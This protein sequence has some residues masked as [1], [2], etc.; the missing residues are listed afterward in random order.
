M[1]TVCAIPDR[2]KAL[3]Y[4]P[5]DVRIGQ[6]VSAMSV[7]WTIFMLTGCNDS[8][9]PAAQVLRPAPIIVR[10]MESLP[11]VSKSLPDTPLKRVLLATYPYREGVLV[12]GLIQGTI[13]VSS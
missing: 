3:P 4:R 5:R 10:D 11:Q 9:A 7:I 12:E 6:V 8:L 1:H 13:T 2:D